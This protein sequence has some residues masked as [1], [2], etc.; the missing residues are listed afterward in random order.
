MRSDFLPFLFDPTDVSVLKDVVCAVCMAMP[1]WHLILR[2]MPRQKTCLGA[3]GALPWYTG[4]WSVCD[5]G[6]GEDVC[7]FT[8]RSLREKASKKKKIKNQVQDLAMM[9]F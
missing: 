6:P 2:G 8:V 4:G 5:T 9:V 3:A 1:P 7:A